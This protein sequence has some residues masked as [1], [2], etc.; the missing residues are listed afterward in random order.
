MNLLSVF[1]VFTSV[2]CIYVALSGLIRSIDDYAKRRLGV[3]VEY[4]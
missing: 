2:N 4:A 3:E 1:E